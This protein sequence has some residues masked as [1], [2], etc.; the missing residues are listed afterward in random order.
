MTRLAQQV[1]A[2]DR[3]PM[4]RSSDRY[5]ASRNVTIVGA[6]V[7]LSLA[8]VKVGGGL[9]ANSQALVADGVHSFSDLA[10]D[11]IVVVAARQADRAPDRSH[12]YGHG[13]IETAMTL[14][15]GLVL[16]ST[17]V[18]IGWGAV[19]GLQ[20][21][22]PAPSALAIWI[23]VLSIFANEGLFSYTIRA[24]DQVN[25]K[26]LRANAWHHR[27][28]SISSVVVLVG[29]IGSMAGLPYLDPVAAI[30]VAMM[31]AK[32][33]WDTGW[34]AIRELTDEALQHEEVVDIRQVIEG[35]EGVRDLHMLRSRQV[36][37][38]ALVDVHVIVDPRLTVSEGHRIA[39]RIRD[40]VVH[41][42]DKVADVLV[43]VDSEDDRGALLGRHLPL[44]DE[45]LRIIREAIASQPGAGN[46]R[47]IRL[48]YQRDE[49]AV[50]ILLP[51]QNLQPEE[52]RRMARSIVDVVHDVPHV[53]AAEVYFATNS[54][55]QEK[56]N[57]G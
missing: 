34:N 7:N 13:R 10:T 23:A 43:H 4:T 5:A 41:S 54:D 57:G 26:L 50:E 37:A 44:R 9:F 55:G 52:A 22:G 39:E 20:Q 19:L 48:H 16:L 56:P 49:I 51:L 29:I 31:I 53:A 12:P 38:Y 21:P 28:D 46:V 25:S 47:D 24:A 14:V 33:G 3:D 40:R 27:T 1:H 35:V 18:A 17:A 11:A 6:T 32:I 2:A 36:G 8:L 15:L 45:M 30:G 42:V